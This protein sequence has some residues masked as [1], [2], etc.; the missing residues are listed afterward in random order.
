MKY[1]KLTL[2]AI[3]VSSLLAGCN[4][5]SGRVST[6]AST[7]E[8]TAPV[9]SSAVRNMVSDKGS[10]IEAIDADSPAG[11]NINMLIDGDVNT[12]FL[13]FSAQ[14]NV[15]FSATKAYI[16]KSYQLTSAND[17]PERD[18]SSWLLEGSNDKEN[19]NEIDSQSGQSFAD[20]FQTREFSLEDNEEEYQYYRFTLNYTAANA[21]GQDIFQLAELAM[22]VVADAPIVA[23]SSSTTTPEVGEHVIFWD[24]SL[25]NPT[26]WEWTFEGGT[27]ATSTE[28]S[29]LVSF[30][31]LGPKTVTLKASNDKGETTLVRADEIRVWDPNNPW[32]GFP[33]P[34]VSYK[35]NLP[36]H[37]GQAAL[38]RVMPDLTDVIHQVSLGVAQKLYHNVTE[39]NVFESLTFETGE[40]DFPAAK[41]GTDKD[42]VLLF[43]LNHIANLEGQGDQAL[44]DEVIGVLWHE[45]THGYNNVP[46]SG[47]YQPGNELHSYLEGLANY[48]RID[49][50]YLN[51]SPDWIESWNQDAYNQTSLFLKWVAETNRN[52]DFIREFNATARNV[53]SWSFDKAFKAIFGEQRGINEVFGEY[54][55]HLKAL[56]L[57]PFPEPIAGFKNIAVTEGVVVSTNATHIGIWGEG[58]DKTID[59]NIN[60]KFNAVIE[61]PWWIPEY[62]PSLS[63]INDVNAVELVFELPAP[64]RVE[65]YSFTTGNDNPH[66]DPT[67][68]VL[69]GSNDGDTWLTLAENSYPENPNRLNDIPF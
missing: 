35:K 63:P 32:D 68:W 42:M 5:G 53:S 50:G 25:A 1:N 7:P 27:P 10:Q 28:R 67:S 30:D 37:I 56:G 66:R 12:K 31:A 23:F 55:A 58:P 36:E 41:A 34:V 59:N 8:V 39:I 21:S 43:D 45:L 4:D 26:A 60:K 62:A 47:V 61:E 13:T 29:P 22:F 11:E 9:A 33:K 54:Q 46:D 14:A 51:L 65:K 38:E 57:A 44:R 2:I 6:P 69:Y 52:T 16:L 18:P 64:E 49:A 20:R 15:I 48:I 24:E 19:W 3:T 40:Y 17:A